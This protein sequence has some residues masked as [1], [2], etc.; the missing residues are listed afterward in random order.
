MARSVVS[1]AGVAAQAAEAPMKMIATK[2]IN[3]FIGQNP[4]RLGV[5][6]PVSK[7]IHRRMLADPSYRHW[8]QG[9]RFRAYVK[10]R[11]P[12]ALYLTPPANLVHGHFGL[13]SPALRSC[14]Q[15]GVR[16]LRFGVLSGVQ[17]VHRSVASSSLLCFAR[18]MAESAA[19]SRPSA[20]L[21]SSG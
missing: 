16:S 18:Y 2:G 14:G 7:R 5:C 8:E 9:G 10:R 19:L 17:R 11:L 13:H 1:G 20:V 21:A 6:E 4:V 15:S 3:L 12:R